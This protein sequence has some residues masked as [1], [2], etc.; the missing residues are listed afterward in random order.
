MSIDIELGTYIDFEVRKMIKIL[1]FNLVNT[2]EYQNMIIF[3]QK[4]TLK[5]V[6]KRFMSL[7]NYQIMVVFQNIKLYLVLD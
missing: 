4:V 3:L 6:Q 1:N 5:I 7:N 2:N